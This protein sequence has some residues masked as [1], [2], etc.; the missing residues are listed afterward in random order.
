MADAPV[1]PETR[2]VA[3]AVIGMHG[4]IGEAVSDEAIELSL[5]AP[6]LGGAQLAH[7]EPVHVEFT[8]R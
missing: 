4:Q 1:L 6:L 5:P 8:K 7:A 2:L 3:V